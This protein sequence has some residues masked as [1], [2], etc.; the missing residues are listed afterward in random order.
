MKINEQN[1]T[2]IPDYYIN[3]VDGNGQDLTDDGQLKKD[4]RHMNNSYMIIDVPAPVVIDIEMKAEVLSILQLLTK[5][6]TGN[7]AYQITLLYENNTLSEAFSDVV[8]IF[9]LSL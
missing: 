6:N 5:Y 8:C 3:V 4:L 9:S 7:V 2:Y 1:E